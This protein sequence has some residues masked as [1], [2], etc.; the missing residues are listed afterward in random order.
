MT[1]RRCFHEYSLIINFDDGARCLIC[2]DCG[3]DLRAQ[4]GC[5]HGTLTPLVIAE[6]ARAERQRRLG[7]PV[8]DDGEDED[9]SSWWPR[10][11]R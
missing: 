1:T 4:A 5:E 3:A 6:Q 8:V 10:W 7:V 2:A 9:A 11:L